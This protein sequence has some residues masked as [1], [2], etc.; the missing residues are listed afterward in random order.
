[1]A[2]W[3]RPWSNEPPQHADLYHFL[4]HERLLTGCTLNH[5]STDFDGGPARGPGKIRKWL[6][7]IDWL[8]TYEEGDEEGNTW[9]MVRVRYEIIAYWANLP[10]YRCRS[11]TPPE[12]PSEPPPWESRWES[13]NPDSSSP[14]KKRKKKAKHD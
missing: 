10:V 4:R 13:N 1:M 3:E 2:A 14:R 9:V 12:P 5:I 11:D 7:R 8:E 6:E